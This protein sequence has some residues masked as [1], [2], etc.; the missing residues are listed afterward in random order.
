MPGKLEGGLPVNYLLDTGASDNF[1]A[2]TTFNQLPKV[3]RAKLETDTATASA[4]NGGSITIYG[5]LTLSCRLRGVHLSIPFRVA[6]ITEDAILGMGFF[7]QN[8]CQLDLDQGV[9]HVGDFSIQCVDRT[10]YP[11]SAKVQVRKEVI[12][13]ASTE[14][15]IPC[16]L[17]N[18]TARPIGLIENLHTDDR[19]FRTATSIV[20]TDEKRRVTARCINPHSAPITLSAGSVIG[21]F[22]VLTDEQIV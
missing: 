21:M 19:G 2:R 8:R 10:G 12:I 6:N 15:Q 11:L 18:C 22:S 4:A 16:H 7:K 20:T 17:T 1:L 13:P 9:L 14:K 3:V 5:T